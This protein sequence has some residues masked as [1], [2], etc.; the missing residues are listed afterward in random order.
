VA[1]PAGFE[2]S[3]SVAITEPCD[4]LREGPKGEAHATATDVDGTATPA[5]RGSAIDP[6][7]RALA[8]AA[9]A[10]RWDVVAQLAREL[11]ARR[12]ASAPNVVPLASVKVR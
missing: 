10:G 3:I 11:E 9:E 2:S 12:L 1:S 4:A 6:L 7:E 5:G 8:L